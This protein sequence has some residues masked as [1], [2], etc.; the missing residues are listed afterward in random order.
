[1]FKI[2]SSPKNSK[3]NHAHQE[4]MERGQMLLVLA[5]SMVGLL[6]AAGLA[7]DG[8]VL[9]LRKAQ[10]DR[11]LD[12]A[13]LAGVVDLYHNE[14][15]SDQD[16]L[17][18]ANLRGLQLLA[19]NGV[20]V[21]DPE[22]PAVYTVGPDDSTFG[23]RVDSPPC[24]T[25]DWAQFEY[26][27]EE[28]DGSIPGAI[29][30]FA[31]AEWFSETYFMRLLGFDRVP[32]RGMAEAEYYALAD[33]YASRT[34][35]E[36]IVRASTQSVFGPDICRSYGDRYTKFL[37]PGNPNPEW[38]ELAGAYTYRIMIPKDYAS[39]YDEVRVEI[40]DP[41][42]LNNFVDQKDRWPAWMRNGTAVKVLQGSKYYDPACPDNGGGQKNRMHTCFLDTGE[43]EAANPYWFVRIDENRGTGKVGDCGAP[44]AYDPSRNTRTLYRLYYYEET[45][46]G[47]LKPVDLAY[48]IG[49]DD[50]K[51]GGEAAL[52]DMHWVSPT[53]DSP[54]GLA[55]R[56][57]TF[58]LNYFK[59]TYSDYYWYYS[60][61]GG[62][63][64]LIC[65][66]PSS[67]GGK[68]PLVEGE[69]LCFHK[70]DV[71]PLAIPEG[72]SANGC[73]SFRAAYYG[74]EFV[75]DPLL[76]FPD[77]NYVPHPVYTTAEKCSGNGDFIVNLK[78]EMKNPFVSADGTYVLYLDIRPLTGASEN[79]F[80][81]WAG[82]P[83]DVYE[84]PAEVNARNMFIMNMLY[85]KGDNVTIDHPHNSEGITIFGLGHLP[86]NSTGEARN[87]IPL[88]YLGPETAGQVVTVQLF[89]A[90]VGTKGPIYFYLED[91][92]LTDWA[93]CYDD[94]GAKGSPKAVP[95]SLAPS[96]YGDGTTVDLSPRLGWAHLE[97][98]KE[99]ATTNNQWITYQFTLPSEYSGINFYGSRLWVHYN[100]G[101]N[102]TFSW[103]LT[104]T[105][106]P[107]LTQ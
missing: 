39:S 79:G 24:D 90:D 16:R 71:E 65:S 98:D 94:D 33:V 38:Q 51:D 50:Y 4:D 23:G 37:N 88:T 101:M 93:A 6:V 35:I 104:T 59:N 52:T 68:K 5:F 8:G 36:G 32:I 48:Y 75:S 69:V 46:S 28:R 53:W 83:R 29:R 66:G 40:F 18:I 80:E 82:P 81:I 31:R 70:D 107:I 58:D 41:D 86:M 74:E 10:L 19:A 105:G 97:G 3:K 91:V 102:D 26:C 84:V 57:P 25:I 11:S 22:D 54:E 95:C 43:P 17:D 77:P 60:P 14:T 61:E 100:T 15:G 56:M 9:F 92:P 7:I 89:D 20:I 1:M 12:A 99:H 96:P 13:V 45:V 76:Y 78:T 21:G 72:D 34:Q 2:I 64:P 44:S 55:E 103:R 42:T 49:E 73:E 27:G 63:G 85:A 67:V 62:K 30:Y 87:E 106:S 47:T